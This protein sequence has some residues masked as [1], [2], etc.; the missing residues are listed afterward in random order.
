M[1]EERSSEC[2]LMNERFHRLLDHSRLLTEHS[3]EVRPNDLQHQH[4]MFPIWAL[5]SKM[6]QKSED[7]F[8]SRMS[9][10]MGRCQ[11]DVTFYLL[12]T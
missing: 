8:G 6:I 7:A 12:D 1:V 10:E 2:D 9:P 11:A 3:L 4:V 5:D